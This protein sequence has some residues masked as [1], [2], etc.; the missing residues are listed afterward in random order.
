M[1]IIDTKT[2]ELIIPESKTNSAA[3]AWEYYLVWQGTDGGVY[4][5]L[6]TDFTEQ[7]NIQGSILNTKSTNITK[8]FQSSENSVLLIAEDLTENE[9]DTIRGILRAKIIRR[10]YKDSTFDN[11]AIV[12]SKSK[13]SKSEFRYSL[14]LEVLEVESSII[15]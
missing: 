8:L 5:W 3:E 1:A 7:Q 6:F 15:F 4:S 13:K 9:F 2:C 14:Q 10:Y 11:L 12:T